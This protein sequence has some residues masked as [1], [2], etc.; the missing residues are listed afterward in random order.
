MPEQKKAVDTLLPNPFLY[1]I[2]NVVYDTSLEDDLVRILRHRYTRRSD[3]RQSLAGTKWI[4][5]EI[6]NLHTFRQ[7]RT[8][9]PERHAQLDSEIMEARKARF[10]CV[11]D[12]QT[13]IQNGRIYWNCYHKLTQQRW[14]NVQVTITS[15]PNAEQIPLF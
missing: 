4:H 11:V 14:S 5:E 7:N 15:T 1:Q 2:K 12:S 9:N 10:F 6:Q 3:A 13:D 8:I